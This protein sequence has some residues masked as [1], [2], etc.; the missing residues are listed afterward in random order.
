M[1]IKWGFTELKKKKKLIHQQNF[2]KWPFT[3]KINL[4]HNT[5]YKI[6]N[7]NKE[8]K[9]GK[10][11]QKDKKSSTLKLTQEKFCNIITK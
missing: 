3:H 1:F 9:I 4:K 10:K 5:Q 8:F 11:K 2:P 7:T 6:L